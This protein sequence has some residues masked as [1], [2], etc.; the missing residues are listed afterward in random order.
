MILLTHD[1]LSGYSWGKQLIG[2]R[3]YL[4]SME[5]AKQRTPSTP[6]PGGIKY[7]K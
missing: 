4:D 7:H 2:E 3:K 1:M 5:I 6:K